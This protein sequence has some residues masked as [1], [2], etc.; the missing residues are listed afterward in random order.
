[1]ENLIYNP[2][3]WK[4]GREGGTAWTPERLNNIEQ[5]ILQA[6]NRLNEDATDIEN[7]K[8]QISQI[9]SNL[10]SIASHNIVRVSSSTPSAKGQSVIIAYPD[11]FSM[12]NCTLMSYKVLTS[13]DDFVVNGFSDRIQIILNR[14]GIYVYINHDSMVNKHISIW[15]Y[16]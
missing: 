8:N 15:L 13:S 7:V 11:G 5:G 12:D 16:S 3:E 10:G 14:N 1:M 4:A 2:T 9:N 6:T